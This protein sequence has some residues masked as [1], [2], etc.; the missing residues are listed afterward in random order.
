MK[1]AKAQKEI[2]RWLSN[3]GFKVV[4][5]IN[6]LDEVYNKRIVSILARTSKRFAVVNYSY[7]P[8]SCCSPTVRYLLDAAK[9]S[10]LQ[11]N[12]EE[13]AKARMCK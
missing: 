6:K 4:E 11:F 7:A 9:N 12:T 8:C 10:L 3:T 13:E 2:S 1:N 5:V